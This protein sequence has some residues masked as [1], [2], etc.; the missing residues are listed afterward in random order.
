MWCKSIWFFIT[1]IRRAVE[2]FN[3]LLLT[4]EIDHDVPNVPSNSN[5]NKS[6]TPMD[7]F[8]DIKIRKWKKISTE[9][10]ILLIYFLWLALTLPLLLF[11]F[12]VM[13]FHFLSCFFFCFHFVFTF[14]IRFWTGVWKWIQTAAISIIGR[15][16]W[17]VIRLPP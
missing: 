9:L 4:A 2:P 13:L 17:K 11:F 16:N 6:H 5:L 1:H 7:P 3:C 15:Y 8:L 14:F 12:I 10:M